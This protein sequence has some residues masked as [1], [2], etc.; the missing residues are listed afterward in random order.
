MSEMNGKNRKNEIKLKALSYIDEDI[1]DKNTEKRIKRYNAICN[2][3]NSGSGAKYKKTV[4]IAVAAALILALMCAILIPLLMKDPDQPVVDQP[5]V[6]L[7]DEKQVSVYKGMSVAG[8]NIYSVLEADNSL[9]LDFL[10]SGGNDKDNG[11]NSGGDKPMAMR[12]P[13]MK[14]ILSEL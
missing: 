2:I 9:T 3:R 7:P 6:D 8:D 11:N 4:I 5:V 13:R 12:T 14:K 10:A 1:I